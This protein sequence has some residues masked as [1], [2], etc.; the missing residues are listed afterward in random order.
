MG[1]LCPLFFDRKLIELDLTGSGACRPSAAS[2]L[3][4]FF[5]VQFTRFSFLGWARRRWPAFSLWLLIG[6]EPLLSA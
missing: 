6:R 5:M 3:I 1:S 2:D 4:Q